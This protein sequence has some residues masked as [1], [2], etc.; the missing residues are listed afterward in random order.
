MNRAIFL[1]ILISIIIA[2][3]IMLY[4]F[5][6]ETQ[7]R[8]ELKNKFTEFEKK[9][10]EKKA[11]GYDVTDAEFFAKKARKAFEADKYEEAEKLLEEAFKVLEKAE[12]TPIPSEKW[13]YDGPI[14]ETH[15]YYYPGHSFKEITEQIPQLKDLGIRTIY[16]MPIWKYRGKHPLAIYSIYDYYKINP[17]FGTSNDLKEL[18]D[19]AHRYDMKVVL[20]FITGYTVPGSVVYNKN[21]TIRIKLDELQKKTQKLG[22]KLEYNTYEGQPVVYYGCKWTKPRKCE[23]FGRIVGDEVILHHYPRVDWGPA[24]DRTNPELIEYLTKVAVYYVKE[25]DIDGFRLDAP[26]NNWNPKIISGDHSILELLKNIKKEIEIIKPS[27]VLISESPYLESLKAEEEIPDPVLDEVCDAS[28]SYYFYANLIKGKIKTSEDL[29]ETIFNEKIWYNRTR[30]RFLETHDTE[31]I[32]KIASQL[33]KPYIVLISTIPGVPMIQAGEEIGAKNSYNE[34]PKVNWNGSDYK[35]KNF[36]RKIFQIRNR[37]NA[38]KYGTIEKLKS[39]SNILLYLRAYRD[40]KVIIVIN[41]SGK[42]IESTIELSNLFKKHVILRDV[43]NNKEFVI[44]DP[45]NFRISVPAYSSM[46]WIADSNKKD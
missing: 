37:N 38:L 40:E 3:S 42:E 23:V 19:T 25:Y 20:D 46:I 16:L 39:G 27:A 6:V 14:Y 22:W 12:I 45:S 13:L 43:L 4:I 28:Y 8:E 9:Y 44:H 10:E 21:W 34:N 30:I 18:V 41:P 36:I 31:R 11:L 7:E 1:V 2:G 33:N 35:L 5:H 24:I 17:D 29:I 26:Q 15:P 32:N